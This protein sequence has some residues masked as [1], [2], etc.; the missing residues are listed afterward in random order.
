MFIVDEKILEY[1]FG[2]SG[3]KYL[4]RGP[5]INFGVVRFK[6]GEDFEAHYHNVM[7]ENFY[8]LEG[9]VDIYIDGVR[10]TLTKGKFIH[11]EPKEIHY[12]INVSKEPV[13][14]TF[15]LGPYAEA[16]KIVVDSPIVK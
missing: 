14:L 7:E 5:R 8:C 4:I 15:A 12:L 10:H 1:R 16:D 11:V 13:K 9:T 6:P 2:D 3:P